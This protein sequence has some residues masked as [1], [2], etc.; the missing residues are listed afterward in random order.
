MM[1]EVIEKVRY[2]S[3]MVV[4]IFWLSGGIMVLLNSKL[5]MMIKI[6]IIKLFIRKMV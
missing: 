3:G 5:V 6:I 2:I 1:E 4:N